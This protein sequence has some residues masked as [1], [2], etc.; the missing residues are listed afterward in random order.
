MTFAF[1]RAP[2]LYRKGRIDFDDYLPHI[3]I[4]EM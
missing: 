2:P 1:E 3:C 4:E